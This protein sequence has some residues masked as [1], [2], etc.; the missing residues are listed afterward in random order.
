MTLLELL[1]K[2]L[3]GKGGWPEGYSVVAHGP[4]DRIIFHAGGRVPFLND[5]HYEGHG[6]VTHEQYEA[7]LAASKQPAWNGE[8]LPQVGC[9]FEYESCQRWNKATM[10][11]CGDKFAIVDIEGY[12]ESYLLMDGTLLRPIRTEAE[13]RRDAAIEDMRKALGHGAGLIEVEN[14]YRAIEC[15]NVRGVKLEVA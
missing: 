7:A 12:G 3:P 14:I 15:G 5:I 10:K 11:F 4:E 9:D 2:E 1:V 13:R 6:V 8:G